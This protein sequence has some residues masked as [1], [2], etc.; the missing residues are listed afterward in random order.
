LFFDFTR[1]VQEPS[2]V[3]PLL[4][5]YNLFKKR[6][7]SVLLKDIVIEMELPETQ[8]NIDAGMFMI[9]LEMIN[10]A[11]DTIFHSHRPHM[12][13]YK[14][15]T[16][17]EHA[18]TI[19]Y[20][21]LYLIGFKEFKQKTRLSMLVKSDTVQIATLNELLTTVVKLV[22]KV[23]NS[24]VQI[25]NAELHIT[26]EV[27]GWRYFTYH[28]PYITL[29][30]LVPIIAIIE[31]ASLFFFMIMILV[32][33]KYRGQPPPP[34]KKL[35]K[36]KK[37]EPL[38]DNTLLTDNIDETDNIKIVETDNVKIEKETKTLRKRKKN[39]L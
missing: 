30:I 24:A 8:Q 36:K 2:C 26:S 37:E 34:T 27:V 25:Y 18:E 3:I 33:W 11:N 9:S 1:G 23:S 4:G 20:L 31:A 5:Q 6:D 22:A 29:F 14:G 10:S 17:Y 32:Y 39:N 7:T 19:A 15:N 16:L 38:F 28:H 21:P 13:K 12:L 35:K